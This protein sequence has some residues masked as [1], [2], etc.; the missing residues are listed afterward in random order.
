MR[1]NG[2]NF[3]SFYG[4]SIWVFLVGMEY[5]FVC[6]I[7]YWWKS[8]DCIN[9]VGIIYLFLCVYVFL[10]GYKFNIMYIDGSR[11]DDVIEGK[12]RNK[13]IGRSDIWVKG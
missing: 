5:Y 13:I 4:E 9:K 8:D 12:I 2:Y 6:N 11:G 1:D 10:D 7:F 3:L